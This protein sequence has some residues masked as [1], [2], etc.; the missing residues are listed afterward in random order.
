M[1][2]AVRERVEL[3]GSAEKNAKIS[4]NYQ[5]EQFCQAD[6]LGVKDEHE[7]GMIRDASNEY[8]VDNVVQDEDQAEQEVHDEDQ[9][10]QQA[11][12]GTMGKRDQAK[13]KFQAEKNDKTVGRTE[14]R[15][16]QLGRDDG[17]GR[18]EHHCRRGAVPD[19][20]TITLCPTITGPVARYVEF[21]LSYNVQIVTNNTP[22]NNPK[23]DQ[24]DQTPE[25]EPNP[26]EVGRGAD[27]ADQMPDEPNPDVEVGGADQADQKPGAELNHGVEVGDETEPNSSTEEMTRRPARDQAEQRMLEGPA[28]TSSSQIEQ[29]A[30]QCHTTK[31]P[32]VR[33]VEI[34]V[35]T[36]FVPNLITNF[37]KETGRAEQDRAEPC[38]TAKM[39]LKEEDLQVQNLELKPCHTF[40]TSQSEMPR[41]DSSQE[42]SRRQEDG[43][44]R[45]ENTRR[46]EKKN[47]KENAV[48]EDAR[49]IRVGWK[50]LRLSR[51]FLQGNYDGWKELDAKDT[52]RLER[53]EKK[54]KAELVSRKKIRFGKAGN[55]KITR[56]E[57]MLIA[58]NTRKLMELEEVRMNL[59]LR[60]EKKLQ[61]GRKDLG[62]KENGEKMNK[63]VIDPKE[64]HWQQLAARV[65]EIEKSEQW[66]TSDWLENSSLEEQNGRLYA[67]EDNQGDK[68]KI[69]SGD[70]QSD[71]TRLDRDA[72]R[73]AGLFQR[74][75][76]MTDKRVYKLA[77]LFQRDGQEGNVK[78]T[79]PDDGLGTVRVH[80]GEGHADADSNEDEIQPTTS[81]EEDN[82]LARESGTKKVF[83]MLRQEDFGS[84]LPRRLVEFGRLSGRKRFLEN[85]EKNILAIEVKDL[86]THGVTVPHG[87]ESEMRAPRLANHGTNLTKSEMHC[88]ERSPGGRGS[89]TKKKRGTPR[90]KLKVNAIIKLFENSTPSSTGGNIELLFSY[91]TN[92][93]LGENH[94]TRQSVP[95]ICVGQPEKGIETRPRDPCGLQF[96]PGADW[97]SQPASGGHSQSQGWIQGEPGP[98][99]E[100]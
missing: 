42:Y 17:T 56:L 22:G 29:S 77:G 86:D 58:S 96:R 82:G 100:M 99:Q 23:S 30:R 37:D 28:D 44:R 85:E 61:T 4:Y 48:L 20:H 71:N 38:S 72:E 8:N 84:L 2:C 65:G 80:S 55:H 46:Q 73:L 98:G 31:W 34:P 36:N 52:R 53:E 59:N 57:E 87:I 69:A 70:N 43:T 11:E 66:L 68:T 10:E 81:L 75:G 79:A 90:A 26:V 33:Y 63:M 50:D 62:R 45:K 74:D 64:E 83:K 5:T 19:T 32:V 14:E 95:K 88:Q 94:A 60:K 7:V 27:Q 41:E 24:A 47:R 51:M 21:P 92:L 25:A 93:N 97:P 35:I 67:S 89:I 15:A 76:S 39:R 3:L 13:H 9:A 40:N 78:D 18:A 16:E 12:K 49:M 6:V 54:L 91:E 1:I